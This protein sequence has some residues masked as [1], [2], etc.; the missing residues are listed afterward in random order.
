[1][2]PNAPKPVAA[3]AA[4]GAPAERVAAGWEVHD[5]GYFRH[6][7]TGC[8]TVQFPPEVK[9]GKWERLD[10]VPPGWKRIQAPGDAYFFW[11]PST[12]ARQWTP[13][14]VEAGFRFHPSASAAPR[15][16]AVVPDPP[17]AAAA[18]AQ[19]DHESASSCDSDADAPVVMV[20]AA[21]PAALPRSAP[22][23]LFS[24]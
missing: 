14:V 15:R 20:K 11:N 18:A 22:P 10:A 24:R 6:S 13:P 1:M 21:R 4:A 16:P 23:A 5:A 12:N 7:V 19:A 2:Q 3:A 9:G 17:A 8:A